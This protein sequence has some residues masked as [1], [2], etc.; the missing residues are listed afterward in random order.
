MSTITNRRDASDPKPPRLRQARIDRQ[1]RPRRSGWWQPVIVFFV[2]VGIAYLVAL[3]YDKVQEL[4]FI[5]PYP[6]QIVSTFL[7]P[8]YETQLAAQ[9]GQSALVAV[10]GLAIAIVIGMVWAILMAQAKWIERSLFPYA[11][12][13]QCVPILALVP[14]IASLYGYAFA[15]RV[16]V[17]AFIAIFPMVSNTLFGLQSVDQGQRELFK[18]QGVGR[19]TLLTKLQFPAALPAIFVGLRTAAGLSVIGAIVGDQFFQQGKPG[20]GVLIQVSNARLNGPATFATIIV[21]SLLGVAVFLFFG[22]LGR[23]TIGKWYQPN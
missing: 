4:G 14:L 18:L 16:I 7:D 19:W 2:L 12:F 11:V 23:V 17:A 10:T 21:A 5:V 20:L 9:L 6:H 8:N 15:S 13:L 22:W 3:Y 1:F